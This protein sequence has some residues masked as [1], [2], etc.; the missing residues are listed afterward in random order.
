MPYT[1]T[2]DVQIWYETIGSPEDEA[3]VLIAG[4][5]AQLIA[6]QDP[7][8]HSLVEAG[9]RVVRF[10]NRD[11]GLS[12]RFGGPEDLDGG[13][14]MDDLALDVIRVLDTEGIAAAHM[15]GHSMGG[16]VAQYLALD[17]PSRVLSA[18]LASTI[19][20]HDP[21][22][23]VTP[24]V[25]EIFTR[26]Q[27]RRS[28]EEVVELSV[29]VQAHYAGSAYPFDADTARQLAGLAYDRGYWPDGLPRQWAALARAT[30]RLE[31]L[32]GLDLPVLILHGREDRTC[33]WRAAVDMALAIEDSELQVYAGMGHV[34]VPELW[35]DYVS[36]IVRTAR[37]G[38]RA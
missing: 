29:A 20:G 17:H 19:P 2:D 18:T 12:Q 36:A 25:P 38:R 33:A 4:G 9:Y 26:P 6:W 21:A 22:W 16:I 5:G 15:V 37:R 3:I 13:Y 24:G 10:D 35:P 32:R 34:L 27:E 23:V 30:E 31:R 28:R 14:E 1:T 7:F 8:C 11:T